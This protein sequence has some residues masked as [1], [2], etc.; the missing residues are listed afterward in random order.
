MEVEAEIV[1]PGRE[2]E[3]ASVSM[4]IFSALFAGGT[5]L[6]AAA[7]MGLMIFGK[8]LLVSAVL[9]WVW[10]RIFSPEFTAWVFGTTTVP[11]WKILLLCALA[12]FAV[13]WLAKKD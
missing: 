11:Y 1:T 5:V 6:A 3:R 9:T 10:P 12:T 13:R 7:V 4:P 8:V 2:R